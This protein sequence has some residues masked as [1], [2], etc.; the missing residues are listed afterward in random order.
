MRVKEGSKELVRPERRGLVL[1]LICDIPRSRQVF[2]QPAVG[3]RLGAA[4]ILSV[5]RRRR[6]EYNGAKREA[7]GGGKE[8]CP[9]ATSLKARQVGV[10]FQICV[11]ISTLYPSSPPLPANLPPWTPS[12]PAQQSYR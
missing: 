2:K 7:A 11:S 4:A 3:E 12:L 6:S 1:E 8:I 9:A 5:G 10:P